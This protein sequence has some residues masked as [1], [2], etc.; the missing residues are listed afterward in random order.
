MSVLLESEQLKT[1]AKVLL[2]NSK[3]SVVVPFVY[4]TN[5][6]QQEKLLK[7][8][9]EISSFK[10]SKNLFDHV[11]HLIPSQES[12]YNGTIGRRFQLKETSREKYDLPTNKSQK[13]YLIT[14]KGE[15]FSFKIERVYLFLFETE[16]GFLVYD[17]EHTSSNIDTIVLT[18]YQLKHLHHLYSGELLHQ[19]EYFLKKQNGE[20]VSL[21]PE[22]DWRTMSSITIQLLQDITVKNY[23]S[24]LNGEPETGLVFNFILMDEG[25]RFED[26]MHEKLSRNLFNLRRSFKES[27]KPSPLEFDLDNNPQ[28]LQLFQNSYWGVSLEGLSNIAY[29]TGDSVTDEFFRNYQDKLVAYFY[30][31]LL[32]LH[33]RYGFIHLNAM[34]SELPKEST[35]EQGSKGK[36]TVPELRKKN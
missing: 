22:G 33:Q 25:F 17:I 12:Y 32:A 9:W 15:E 36:V 20:G 19:K 27:Y 21:S 13:M 18:N 35:F 4:D 8:D 29:L 14:K 5:D 24:S 11:N 30:I 7:E 6:F 16:V 3:T 26:K 1:E 2:D 10:D 34:A 23:F 28:I 31:Y